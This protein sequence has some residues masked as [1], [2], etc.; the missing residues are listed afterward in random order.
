MRGAVTSSS[1]SKLPTDALLLDARE[2]ALLFQKLKSAEAAL[3][4]ERSLSGKEREV[5][6]ERLRF[7]EAQEEASRERLARCWSSLRTHAGRGA[8]EAAA[9]QSAQEAD[10]NRLREESRELQASHVSS[11]QLAQ[12]AVE[13]ARQAELHTQ[14]AREE[15]DRVAALLETSQ[16]SALEASDA[17]RQQSDK[18]AELASLISD[19]ERL[20]LEIHRLR[21][22]AQ[23]RQREASSLE[24]AFDAERRSLI[25]EHRDLELRTERELRRLREELGERVSEWQARAELEGREKERLADALDATRRERSE[26]EHRLVRLSDELMAVRGA[27]ASAVLSLQDEDRR[28]CS[29]EVSSQKELEDLR[30][31]LQRRFHEELQTEVRSVEATASRRA[32]A[33]EDAERRRQGELRDELREEL[34]WKAA[35][36]HQEAGAELFGAGEAQLA[37]KGMEV[38][39]QQLLEELQE[40][41]ASCQ[42][43]ETAAI[44]WRAA[45][46]QHESAEKQAV[47]EN[48]RH[49]HQH[50]EE[51]G[52][53]RLRVELRGELRDEMRGWLKDAAPMPSLREPGRHRPQE[54]FA[55]SQRPEALELSGMEAL[56]SSSAFIPPQSRSRGF[57][58]I[59]SHAFQEPV[60]PC[61]RSSS[62]SNLLQLKLVDAEERERK[63][64]DLSNELATRCCELES[65]LEAATADAAAS[66]QR[67]LQLELQLEREIGEYRSRLLASTTKERA[68]HG[69]ASNDLQLLELERKAVALAAEASSATAEAL[70]AKS[71]E[72]LAMAALAQS[73]HRRREGLRCMDAM[74]ADTQELKHSMSKHQH[75]AQGLSDM[76]K[77]HEQTVHRHNVSPAD[78]Q[79]DTPVTEP[80]S[81][82]TSASSKARG[83]SLKGIGWSPANAST[84]WPSSSCAQP[85]LPLPP[86]PVEEPSTCDRPP[87]ATGSSRIHVSDDRWRSLTHPSQ[88]A[89]LALQPPVLAQPS[90]THNAARCTQSVGN[91]RPAAP[92]GDHL[93]GAVWGCGS[94][95]GGGASCLSPP[96]RAR[97][98]FAQN[99]RGS[100]MSVPQLA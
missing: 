85:M 24:A 31:Q 17:A 51:E 70:A 59:H 41:R 88:G 97:G 45:A 53:D 55:V 58:D 39:Q 34:Q 4:D 69:I 62:S 5:I 12:R 15:R 68:G 23:A 90:S 78:S 32:R 46:L 83:D 52:W 86:P 1:A 63:Q 64:A 10:V 33:S 93:P 47:L 71:A 26:Q 38:R 99:R 6:T 82:P 74:L 42:D 72:E 75:L 13:D 30:G 19:R 18:N 22:E 95:A 61:V 81:L 36:L 65:Q 29:N 40:A 76:F 80:S 35:A 16:R 98:S 37:L 57:Q 84:R 9:I 56:D 77:R 50:L 79:G 92:V 100:P 21:Q 96:Q 91:F 20:V 11:E 43:L 94:L 89:G 44:D 25:A 2:A 3:D 73:E 67:A 66:R 49:R 14:E 60:E 8:E 54:S 28:R 87:F 7:A 27:E 48:E